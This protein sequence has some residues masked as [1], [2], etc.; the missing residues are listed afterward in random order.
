MQSIALFIY[1]NNYGQETNPLQ[2]FNG[3]VAMS[4]LK[5][6]DI[7][8]VVTFLEHIRKLLNVDREDLKKALAYD[9]L[10]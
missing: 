9:S 6:D 2:V 7:H 4:H 8:T 3:W 5:I 10:I 1:R